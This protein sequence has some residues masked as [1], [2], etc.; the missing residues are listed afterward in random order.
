[1]G[2]G[3]ARRQ[4]QAAGRR[5]AVRLRLV[6]LRV[7]R[8]VQ[9]ALRV[10]LQLAALLGSLRPL[11]SHLAQTSP[12]SALS[13]WAAQTRSEGGKGGQQRRVRGMQQPAMGGVGQGT[14][15]EAEE[16]R[17]DRRSSADSPTPPP[18]PAAAAGERAGAAARR[19][20][21]WRPST[22]PCSVRAFSSLG[23]SSSRPGGLPGGV[24]APA[25]PGR[26]PGLAGCTALRVQHRPQT[27]QPC[28]GRASEETGGR[29]WLLSQP[30]AWRALIERSRRR[31]APP[32]M[33]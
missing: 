4:A 24:R 15:R 13:L 18:T 27:R 23:E 28:A 7:W 3:R 30:P 31:R 16:E 14:R 8:W 32:A 17:N 26:S 12:A 20:P 25:G 1:M 33:L 19:G 9:Q 2:A 5:L 29:G 6:R 10:L 22:R 21:L 11:G